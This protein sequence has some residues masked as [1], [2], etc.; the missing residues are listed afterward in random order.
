M[1]KNTILIIVICVV[2][3]LLC[4]GIA[5][6]VMMPGD[7]IPDVR[8]SSDI[9]IYDKSEMDAEQIII[10]NHDGEFSFAGI[11]YSEQE[12]E[13]SIA[14]KEEE[15]AEKK[16]QSS[17][18]SV[19][20]SGTISSE[21]SKNQ[22]TIQNITPDSIKMHYTLQ[23]HPDAPLD[24]SMMNVLA[25]E[26]LSV[27]ATSIVDTSGARFSEY[28]LDDPRATV[29]TVF[30]D[31]SV[32]TIMIGNTA[33]DDQGVYFRRENSPNVYLA[34]EETMKMMLKSELDFVDKTI[35]S[36]IVEESSDAKGTGINSVNIKGSFRD[37]EIA[38]DNEGSIKYRVSC[39][40]RKPRELIADYEYV[41]TFGKSLYELEAQSVAAL[42]PDDEALKKY[43]LDDPYMDIAV[44][45]SDGTSVHI[46]CSEKNEDGTV[47][48]MKYKGCVIYVLSEEDASSW[49]GIEYYELLPGTLVVP[50]LFNMTALDIT[51]DGKD[52]SFKVTN[53]PTVNALYEETVKTDI[54]LDDKTIDFVEFNNYID[55][56]KKL[57]RI[58]LCDISPD[59]LE[60]EYTASFSYEKD[61]EK[62]VDVLSVYKTKDGKH[63]ITLNGTDEGYIDS[64]L[65][66]RFLPQL[67]NLIEG[68]QIEI[69]DYTDEETSAETESKSE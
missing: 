60:P 17:G 23:G 65:F 39:M 67:D 37:Y 1:K 42:D 52:Y 54:T 11:N 29:T 62:A 46:L 47:N 25:Y 57:E 61:G 9:L 66:E 55:L 4:A 51:K 50:D 38:T 45:A 14:K 49:Y 63:F 59:G 40:M 31:D 30:S 41:D 6:V 12:K 13:A 34:V 36:A 26:C 28:G 27:S 48:I 24:K 69:I 64:V 22:R 53:T 19:D 56:I 2:I 44:S 8:S 35:S 20:I 18:F 10:T 16:Q 68:K 33:P 32:E 7:K 21:S 3:A 58:D 5:V 15:L 43:G